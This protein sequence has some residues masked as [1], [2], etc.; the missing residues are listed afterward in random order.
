MDRVKAWR[1]LAAC[2]CALALLVPA[3]AVAQ[4]SPASGA[5]AYHT[6]ASLQA[7]LDEL[8][9]RHGG[10]VRSF[11]L[12]YSLEGRRITMIRVSG[13]E[14]ASGRKPAIYIEGG[15]HG[16][17]WIGTE[18]AF[19]LLAY[20]CVNYG[21]DPLVTQILDR[22]ELWF[23]PLT[24]PDGHA[25]VE[26]GPFTSQAL[27]A[28]RKNARDNREALAALGKKID[29]NDPRC[30]PGINLNR[31]FDYHW[32]EGG[33]D[34]P[35][36]RHYRGPAPLTEPEAVAING[37][38]RGLEPVFCLSYHSFRQL[39]WYTRLPDNPA[40]ERR[41]LELATV[42]SQ[43]MRAV[44]GRDYPPQS[45]KDYGVETGWIAG[46]LGIPAV[47]VELRPDNKDTKGGSRGGFALPVDQIKPTV[48]ENIP[49]AVAVFARV[50][51]LDAPAGS[52]R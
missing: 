24:N 36:N 47:L 6:Y 33:N 18:V 27:L 20:L 21:Q 12:A 14:P 41:I 5:Y 39:I 22:A 40:L 8:T 34:H 49:G 38:L 11:T 48:E 35:C 29:P 16:S 42:M 7:D 19:H 15:M 23:A 28:G 4:P 10:L 51:G 30:L 31:Q 13:K 1:R 17:E 3:L 43:A 50:L 9:A 25:R 2:A 26:T 45:S 32:S 44:H 37:F 52:G 46:V